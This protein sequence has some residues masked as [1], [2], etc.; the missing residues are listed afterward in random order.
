MAVAAF[1]HEVLHYR[2]LWALLGIL[3]AIHLFGR[4]G[5]SSAEIEVGALR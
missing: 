1:T 3:A 4:D 2:H 5:K